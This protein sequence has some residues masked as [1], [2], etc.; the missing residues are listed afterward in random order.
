MSDVYVALISIFVK[1]CFLIVL[2]IRCREIQSELEAALK[3]QVRSDH[4]IEA[5]SSERVAATKSRDWHRDQMKEAREA[6]QTLQRQMVGLQKQ[7]ATREATIENLRTES[8][9][10]KELLEVERQTALKEK[11]ALK[12]MLEEQI[13]D[14]LKGHNSVAAVQLVDRSGH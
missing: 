2:Q 12:Q 5:A 7:L 6:R 1:E 9:K 13:Q 11:Q 3:A 4:E 14:E 10:A 8:T